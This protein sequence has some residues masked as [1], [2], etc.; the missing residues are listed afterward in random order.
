MS[1]PTVSRSFVVDFGAG[2][3]RLDRQFVLS[4]S[5]D[6]CFAGISV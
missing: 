2:L 1:W 4:W 5:F 3:Q 6:R